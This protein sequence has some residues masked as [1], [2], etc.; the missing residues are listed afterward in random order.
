MDSFGIRK[1]NNTVISGVSN[2]FVR[3]KYEVA[4]DAQYEYE[5]RVA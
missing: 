5:R 4:N 2:L 3:N 1:V